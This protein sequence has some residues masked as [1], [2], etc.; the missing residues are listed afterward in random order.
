MA[1]SLVGMPKDPAKLWQVGFGTVNGNNLMKSSLS[2]MGGVLVANT[3]QMLLSYL[4][5]AFNNLYTRMF[6]AREWSTYVNER[7][8]LRVTAPIGQQRDTYWLNVPFRFAIPMTIVSGLFHWLASQS[9][10]LVQITITDVKNRDSIAGRIST[11][12]YSPFAIILTTI[13]GSVIA[14]GGVMLGGLKYAPG[15]PMAGGCS[16][17]ISAACHPSPEDVSASLLPVQWGAITQGEKGRQGEEPVGHCGFSSLP[18][19]YPVPGCLYA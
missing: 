12:G 8:P 13:T 4:Y 17:V 18:V 16:V 9:F 11:C 5:L 7:K 19:E 6:V 15:M 3:P 10:F 1:F 2:L 14:V